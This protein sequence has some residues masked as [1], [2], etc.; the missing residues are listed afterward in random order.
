VVDA[1]PGDALSSR[2]AQLWGAALRR[3]G[4]WLAAL[5]AFPSEP[6]VN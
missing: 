6:S 4:G 1:H 3:Q 5:A 2:P